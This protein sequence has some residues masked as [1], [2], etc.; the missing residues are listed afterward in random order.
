MKVPQGISAGV[1]GSMITVRGPKGE[2]SRKFDSRK[3][4]VTLA[5]DELRI[6]PKG[7]QTR[8]LHAMVNSIESHL[9]NMFLGVEEGFEKKLQVVFSHFPITVETKGSE[10]FV[11]NF[12]GEKMPRKAK[13]IGKTQVRV[14]GAEIT[15]SG[16]DREEV[17]QTASN[18]VKCTKITKRDERVFQDGIYYS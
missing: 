14:Q 10:V 3:M 17:G 6:T 13:I 12:L 15:V 2:L 16:V 5:G 7:K 18:V 1:S 11:K 9:K 8:K 4:E